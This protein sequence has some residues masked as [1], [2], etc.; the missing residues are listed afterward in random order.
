MKNIFTNTLKDQPFIIA[1]IGAAG[2][3]HDRWSD[4]G[5]SITP[6]YWY[7]YYVDTEL[8]LL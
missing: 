2:G 1:D 4:L 7:R 3:L 5:S 8:P 6:I